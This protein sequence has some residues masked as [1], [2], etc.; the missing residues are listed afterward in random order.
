MKCIMKYIYFVLFDFWTT[1]IT[2]STIKI[3]DTYLGTKFLDIYSLY[4]P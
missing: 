2:E 4:S 3:P 1:T